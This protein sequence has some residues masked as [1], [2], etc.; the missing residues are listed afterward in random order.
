MPVPEFPKVA[1]PPLRGDLGDF[2]GFAGHPSSRGYHRDAVAMANIAQLIHR[3]GGLAQKQQLVSRGARDLDLTQAVRDGS[4]VRARQGWYTTVD[5]AEPRVRAARVGGRLTGISAIRDWG[6][7]VLASH[8]LHVSVPRNSARL[9]NQWNRRR[10]LTTARGVH[11]H[12]DAPE[13]SERGSAWSVSAVD[14]LIRVVLDEELETAVAAL[15]WAVHSGLLDEIDLERVFL[16]LPKSKSW[17]RAWVDGACE[18]LPESLTRTRLRLA[19]Y[20]VTIQV[21][22]GPQRIDMVIDGTI[23]LEIDGREFHA[24]TFEKDHLKAIDITIAGFH[25]MAVSANMVFTNWGHFLHAVELA[26]ASH[27]PPSFGNSGT[28]AIRASGA[29]QQRGRYGRWRGSS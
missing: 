6:G 28:P 25:A 7:W 19:G 4:A 15:D 8:D 29:P 18:S 17:V 21:P 16:G 10:P 26:M 24:A 23:G 1:A 22:L 13:L 3:L 11:V 14:A 5:E 20:T 9:R 12:W 27:A 2:H